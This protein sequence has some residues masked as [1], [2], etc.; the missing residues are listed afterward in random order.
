[1]SPEATPRHVLVTGAKGGFIGSRL[2]PALEKAG[3]A[4][5][6]TFFEITDYSAVDAAISREK[7]DTIVHLAAISHVPICEKD[8]SLAFRVNLAGTALLL[9]AIRRH[10]PTA[11]LIFASSAQLYAA[12]KEDDESLWDESR[13]VIPQNVYARTKAGAELLIADAAKRGETRATILRLFN[14]TH[15]S[16][17]PEAFLPHLYQQMAGSGGSVTIP[18]GHMD[19]YRDIGGLEDL[20]KAFVAAAK[21]PPLQGADIFNICSGAPKRLDKLANELADALK[22]QV[23]FQLEPNRVRFGESRRIQGSYE[24]FHKATGWKPSIGTEAELISAFLRDF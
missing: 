17:S 19:V 21:N 20:L 15:K 24:K 5:D 22:V 6:G 8:P 11:H 4:A 23:K 12:A 10:C 7:W 3:F 1:M 16:Q 9:E 18:V 13:K 14:H 2:V